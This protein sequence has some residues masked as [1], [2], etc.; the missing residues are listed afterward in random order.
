MRAKELIDYLT[1]QGYNVFPDPNFIPAELPESQLPALFVF[2]TGGY[3]PHADLFWERPT[4]QV[5]VVGKNYKQDFSQMDMTE[6]LAKQ[7]IDHFE[8]KEGF[9]IG[10]SHIKESRALQSNPIP[11][12]LDKQNRPQFSINLL[13]EIRRDI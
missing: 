10:D 2:G 6:Q 12:G 7:L 5:I 4:F 1:T 13:F 9:I 8:K 3:Q 11:L